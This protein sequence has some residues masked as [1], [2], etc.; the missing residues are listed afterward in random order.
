MRCPK[1]QILNRQKLA[2]SM[3][4]VAELLQWVAVR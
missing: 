3:I 1:G 2:L 4:T